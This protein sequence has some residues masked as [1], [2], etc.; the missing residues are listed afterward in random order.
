MY[1]DLR[2]CLQREISMSVL[3]LRWVSRQNRQ[4]ILCGV[5][6][7]LIDRKSVV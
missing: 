5:L 3:S 7:V 6:V 1:A 4:G 2:V